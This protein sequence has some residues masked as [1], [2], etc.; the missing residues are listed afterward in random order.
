[1]STRLLASGSLVL[2]LAACATPSAT[3]GSKAPGSS[4]VSQS[5]PAPPAAEDRSLGLEQYV[6]L[7]I[8][9]PERH[10]S[11]EDYVLAQ[12]ALHALAQ[13]N[14][15]DLPRYQSTRSGPLFARLTAFENVDSIRTLQFPPLSQV[16]L[17]SA[18]LDPAAR[19]LM[20]YLGAH[21][22]SSPFSAEMIEL[23]SFITHLAAE[24][25]EAIDRLPPEGIKN[26]E[27]FE[28]GLAKV[29]DGMGTVVMGA[30][31]TLSERNVY[32]DEE[33]IRFLGTLKLDLPR[34][35]PRLKPLTQ[36]EVPVRIGKLLADEPSPEVK[37]ELEALRSAVAASAP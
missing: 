33:R 2:L 7:G 15:A 18:I 16:Q 5:Q 9:S 28:S 10:W 23:Q 4:Q 22:T 17:V 24:M 36:Q 31:T 14:P 34:L 19:I 13:K 35:L 6:E 25:L 21:S 26:R 20:V 11:G 37:R 30:L 8:P 29:R 27:A 12:Q 32:S 1:M 3:S